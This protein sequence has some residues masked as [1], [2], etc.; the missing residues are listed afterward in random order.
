MLL[1][2]GFMTMQKFSCYRKYCIHFSFL[3]IQQNCIRCLF[4]FF[5]RIQFLRHIE[6]F[7]QRQVRLEV[8]EKS[9]LQLGT[10]KITIST[11]GIGYTNI[12]R[13]VS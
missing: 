4:E 1:H 8:D 3:Q 9:K 10:Y 5:Y 11:V 6:D 2:N 12:N 7:F 13:K